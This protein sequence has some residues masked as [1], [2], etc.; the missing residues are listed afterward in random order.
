MLIRF[1]SANLQRTELSQDLSH[2]NLDGIDDGS[3]E[4]PL[5]EET[6]ILQPNTVLER[7]LVS[8][9]V[10]YYYKMKKTRSKLEVAGWVYNLLALN[11]GQY[12]LTYQNR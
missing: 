3:T 5:V 7:H 2:F 6:L 9:L 4:N 8:I 12:I 1:N 10:R 11:N